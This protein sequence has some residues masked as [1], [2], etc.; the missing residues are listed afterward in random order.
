MLNLDFLVPESSLQVSGGK[1]HTGGAG[2]G[3]AVHPQ[4]QQPQSRPATSIAAGKKTKFGA[5]SSLQ[6][7]RTTSPDR[8]STQSSTGRYAVAAAAAGSV[9]SY[10]VFR[11]FDIT[12]YSVLFRHN[13]MLVHWLIVLHTPSWQ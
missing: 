10:Y 4:Q 5:P 11:V 13:K 7:S 3:A 12:F 9:S 2:A 8:R 1:G 6:A